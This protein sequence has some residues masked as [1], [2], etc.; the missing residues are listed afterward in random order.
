M[1]FLCIR[2]WNRYCSLNKQQSPRGD[3]SH[4]QNR[5]ETRS[6]WR[7]SVSAP[8]KSQNKI[9]LC[10]YWNVQMKA[11]EMCWQGSS[12]SNG[13]QHHARTGKAM[14][15]ACVTLTHPCRNK[16]VQL[17]WEYFRCYIYILYL[18]TI[19]CKII[20]YSKVKNIY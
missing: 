1:Y 20:N 14:N 16:W 2:I 7:Y 5:R 15:E 11:T 4:E 19:L 17:L 13:V 10:V 3:T 9:Q 18:S 12:A 6:T 8:T